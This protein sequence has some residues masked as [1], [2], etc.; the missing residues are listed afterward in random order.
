M[1]KK[2]I[3]FSVVFG[4]VFLASNLAQADQ[5]GSILECTKFST[6][7]KRLA[8]FDAATVSLVNAGAGKNTSQTAM[9][10]S[11]MVVANFGKAQLRDSPVKVVREEAKQ[12]DAQELKNIT[13]KVVKFIYTPSKKFVLFMENGQIWKQRDG[14]RI[15]LPKGEFEV[16]IRK[17]MISG[18]NIIVPTRRSFI[19]V[20]RL[21]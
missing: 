14:S 2:A 13:L 4:G 17:S 20:T 10:S 18:Y 8:C 19:R 16:E 21:K 12:K 7:D 5:L 6:D 11:E 9:P 15:R 3:L 1:S